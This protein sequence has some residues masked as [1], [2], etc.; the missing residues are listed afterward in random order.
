[1]TPISLVQMPPI[2]DTH[3]NSFTTDPLTLA[4]VG[5]SKDLVAL[6]NEKVKIHNTSR[7]YPSQ[8]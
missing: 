6:Y 8:D 1:M 5:P 3:P 2:I 4:G 7:K